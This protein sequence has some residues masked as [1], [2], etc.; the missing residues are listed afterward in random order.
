M[1]EPIAVVTVSHHQ[2]PT[3]G[4][5]LDSLATA[6]TRQ[7]EIVIARSGEP[8]DAVRAALSRPNVRVVHTGGQL[9]YGPAANL[10][11]H[12]TTAELLV[13]ASPDIVWEPGSL[14][15][16]LTAARRWPRGAAFG[17]L[18]HTPTGAVYP[19]A[20]AIPSLGRG[21]GHA[22]CG[23][24]WPTNPWTSAYRVERAAPVERTAGWLAG[25]CL[26]LRRDAFDAVGGF[27]QDRLSYL[28]D[29][30]LGE[31]LSRAGWQNV[32][33]PS[34]VV[35]GGGRQPTSDDPARI[36]AERHRSAWAYLARRYPG[37]R[38]WPVRAMLRL[39]LGLRAALARRVT[40]I[41]AGAEPQ[42]HDD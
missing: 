1:S 21:V 19:S 11:V 9:G 27:A 30:D 8:D 32:Y 16:L 40:R 22:L 36:S 33:V 34:A 3:L 39:G 6:T 5:F 37:V 17:P 7:F 12:D 35:H 26:L 42:R 24:W 13:V 20:R 25:S 29:L 31:R 10:A 41:A 4:R 15:R 23:W 14:D 38:W 28:E 2:G 18:I